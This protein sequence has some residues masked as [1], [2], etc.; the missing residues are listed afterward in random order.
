MHA[1][2]FSIAG[3]VGGAA[4][5]LL[6]LGSAGCKGP[7]SNLQRGCEQGSGAACFQLGVAYYEGKDDKG[8]ALDLD[9]FKAR[10]AF[11]RSCERDNPTA[12]YNLGFMK[13]RGEGG[14]V[15]KVQS[16]V[17]YKKG[18]ELGDTTACAKAAAAYRDGQG[19]A[20][21]LA[22]AAQLAKRGCDK[23]DKDACE[24]YKQLES[25]SGS[26]TDGS[27]LSAEVRQL[28]QSCDT[29][30]A[31][32]CFEAGLRFDEARG[33]P[34]DKS[35]A[36]MAY[37]AACEKDDLRGCHNLGVML[38]DG[39]GIPRNVGNGFSLLNRAC[40]KGQ[41]KSCEVMV[42]KLTKAC[43]GTDADACTI[44]GRFHIKGDKGLESNLSKGVEFLRRGCKLGDKDGCDDLR[45]LG[46][47]PGT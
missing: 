18:C 12:C 7:L 22:V 28:A 35:K 26:S 1:S 8:R 47:A 14:T 27:G 25:Q 46:I 4:L 6:G 38:I 5:A 42:G 32:A 39:E 43:A 17:L 24:I 11:E 31:E 34:I 33:V 23:D 36:A 9:Y 30:N 10:K 3:W 44:L 16:V 15:D 21:D 41:R 40:D 19:V 37:K 13:Q 29:G 20:T 2:R 45:K